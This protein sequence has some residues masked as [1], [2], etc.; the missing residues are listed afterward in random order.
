MK[1]IAIVV[2]IFCLV[3]IA[4]ADVEATVVDLEFQVS[5][6][7]SEDLLDNTSEFS[8][9]VSFVRSSGS[10]Y[11]DIQNHPVVARSA[12][13]KVFS[14]NKL[15]VDYTPGNTQDLGDD[16]IFYVSL[17]SGE[18]GTF[19]ARILIPT[20]LIPKI[21]LHVHVEE[22]DF[23]N[24]YRIITTGRAHQFMID[25]VIDIPT[26]TAPVSLSNLSPKTNVSLDANVSSVVFQT[27]ES[28]NDE[29]ENHIDDFYLRFHSNELSPN[30]HFRLID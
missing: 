2:T 27:V 14:E 28:F 23:L 6:V 8:V 3:D 30:R 4:Q 19:N 18:M 24:P 25:Q 5:S 15:I 29:F 13:L 20:E 10:T 11:S 9:G 16:E 1:Y 7:G 12:R 17:S 21:Q 26:V 22:N